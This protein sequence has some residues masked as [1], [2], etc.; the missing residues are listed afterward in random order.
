MDYFNPTNNI[1]LYIDAIKNRGNNGAK[2][3]YAFQIIEDG[4]FEILEDEAA[5]AEYVERLFGIGIIEDRQEPIE[6][7]FLKKFDATNGSLIIFSFLPESKIN[8]PGEPFDDIAVIFGHKPKSQEMC[9]AKIN[10]E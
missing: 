8:D 5:F 1:D 3:V 4:C 10:F 2:I 7:E 6:E 9:V